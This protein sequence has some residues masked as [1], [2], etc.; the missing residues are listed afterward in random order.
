MTGGSYSRHPFSSLLAQPLNFPLTLT[1]FDTCHEGNYLLGFAHRQLARRNKEKSGLWTETWEFRML[2][3]RK[4][5]WVLPVVIALKER[6]YNLII[7]ENQYFGLN[8]N[9]LKLIMKQTSL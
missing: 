1:V 8:Q 7:I 5:V 6:K 2:M 9:F 3:E 4:D